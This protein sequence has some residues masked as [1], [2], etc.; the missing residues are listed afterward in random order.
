MLVF[1]VTCQV[2]LKMLLEHYNHNAAIYL[3]TSVYMADDS[4]QTIEKLQLYTERSRDGS[5]QIKTLGF[6]IY[7]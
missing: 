7:I 6:F 2:C 5:M 3:K 4:V 1:G